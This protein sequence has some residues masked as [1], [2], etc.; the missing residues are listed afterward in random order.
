MSVSLRLDSVCEIVMGQAPTGVA[1]NNERLGW[2]LIAGAGDFGDSYPAPKKFTKEASKLSQSGD[3]I[4]GIRAT[5][6]EKILSDGVIVLV[7]VLQDYAR[8]LPWI[9]ATFGIG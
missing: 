2:P 4:L 7:E 1:Y 6:G 5:V 3:I 9:T 8:S